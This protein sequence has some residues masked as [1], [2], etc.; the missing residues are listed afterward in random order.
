MKSRNSTHRTD[1]GR[2]EEAIWIEAM[3]QC[4]VCGRILDLDSIDDFFEHNSL[5]W[6]QK[7]AQIAIA[8]GWE[9]SSGRI[10]CE[11]CHSDRVV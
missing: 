2:L 6:A 3:C 11:N 9:Y 7:A 8:A 5:E 4:H 1:D 10:R